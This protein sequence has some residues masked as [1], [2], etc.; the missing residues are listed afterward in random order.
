L[1]D[2]EKTKKK[3]KKNLKKTSK[4]LKNTQKKMTQTRQ[5]P[6]LQAPKF[7]LKKRPKAKF[8][9]RPKGLLAVFC[10]FS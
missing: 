5:R 6:N 7:A 4:N 2:G 3:Y 10:K 8:Q 1:K 9:T